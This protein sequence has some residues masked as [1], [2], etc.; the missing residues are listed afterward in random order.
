MR[1]ALGV[2]LTGRRV[3]LDRLR[4]EHVPDLHRMA[5]SPGWPLAGGNLDDDAF[6]EHLWD[7]SPLQFT[8][9]RRDTDEVV[10]LVRGLRWDQRNETIEVVFG[11]A[12]E[13]WRAGWPF[14]GLVIFGEYLFHG[15]GMRK[16]YFE[17]R[18]ATLAKVRPTVERGLV[19]ECVHRNH[20]AGPD[21]QLEDVE[22]WS[23]SEPMGP[24]VVDRILGRRSPG[25][26]TAA[27]LA[28][29]L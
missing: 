9:L 16:L 22:V 26:G 21:G 13:Y 15:L 3:R 14:E 10:G 11:V 18:G 5:Q 29:D 28:T 25:R 6:V 20:L 24:E 23:V 19:R 1:S 12:P 27:P 7:A 2:P 17:L 4:L 8:M